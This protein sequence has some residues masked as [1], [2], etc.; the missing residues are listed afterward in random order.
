MLA[1]RLLQ[2]L[3]NASR[4][5]I[6][7]P[8][9]ST[10]AQ[11][12]QG[13]SKL[14]VPPLMKRSLMIST[15][16]LRWLGVFS[17]LL[18]ILL[19]PYTSM[20]PSGKELLIAV[21]ILVLPTLFAAFLSFFARFWWVLPIGLWTSFLLFLVTFDEPKIHN[22]AATILAF[23][24]S[25]SLC[26]TPFLALPYRQ[27]KPRKQPPAAFADHGV[28]PVTP[29]APSF[30]AAQAELKQTWNRAILV[31]WSYTWRATL[32]GAGISVLFMI[33]CAIVALLLGQKSPSGFLVFVFGIFAN[34]LASIV[35]MKQILQKQFRGFAI[36]IVPRQ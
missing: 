22:P 30:T 16:W 12:H 29:S 6:L 7:P 8:Q 4:S 5:E 15:S 34:V 21:F 31:W 24:A 11:Q 18:I 3:L 36:R 27:K 35:T 20:G 32:L 17:A 19:F 10:T 33:P 13:Q 25:I 26:A 14:N 1:E 2:N 23:T 28:A 9:P